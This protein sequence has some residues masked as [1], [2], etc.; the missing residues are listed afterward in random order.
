[1]KVFFEVSN[2]TNEQLTGIGT[3]TKNLFKHLR[4]FSGP[5]IYPICSMT[6]WHRRHVVE[7]HISS[8]VSS[9]LIVPHLPSEL[10]LIHIPD[11][12]Y[13]NVTADFRVQTIHDVAILEDEDFSDSGFKKK[14]RQRFDQLLT[15]PNIDQYITVSYFTKARILNFYPHLTG[16][17]KVIHSGSNHLQSP[18]STTRLFPWPYILFTGTLEVRKNILGLLKSFKL[19]APKYPE[20]R[21]VLIGKEGYGSQAILNAKDNHPFRDRILWKQYATEA[22]VANAYRF[23]ELFVFPSFYEGF[24]LPVLEAMRLRC[25]VVCSDIPSLQEIGGKAVRTFSPHDCLDMA[26]VIENVYIN[27]SER[28][29]LKNMGTLQAEKF[30]WDSAASKTWETYLE[31]L[32]IHLREGLPYNRWSLTSPSS[33]F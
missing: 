19:L 5:S 29:L 27:A 21:L 10:K 2:L 13:S 26:G 12:R 25:P 14:F 16:R 30:S 15:D 18:P 20:L 6:R 3:Y 4:T 33:A 23:A 24:G 8:N 1:M 7:K 31:L 28:Y 17:I 11:H 32:R 22:I 9:S